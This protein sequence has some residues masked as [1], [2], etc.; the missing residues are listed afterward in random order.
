MPTYDEAY[1]ARFV[2]PQDLGNKRRTITIAEVKRETVYRSQSEPKAPVYVLY[3]ELPDLDRQ[4]KG[5]P[6]CKTSFAQLVEATGQENSDDWGGYKVVVYREQLK[7]N[8]QGI[9]FCA[10]PDNG[11]PAKAPENI[12][13]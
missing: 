4:P 1:P 11:Q 12:V 7:G 10:V 3:P 13:A 6:L 8:K 9:R 5:I 2:K